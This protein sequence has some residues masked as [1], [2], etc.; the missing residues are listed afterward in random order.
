MPKDQFAEELDSLIGARIARCIKDSNFRTM[1]E[2]A[3][4][5]GVTKSTMSDIVNGN[6]GPRIHTLIKIAVGLEMSIS[7]LVDTKEISDWMAKQA[8]RNLK[9]KKL[10]E[11]L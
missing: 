10:K 1:E 5:I 11:N 9:R 2:F 7:D 4:H 3:H 8:K 6:K